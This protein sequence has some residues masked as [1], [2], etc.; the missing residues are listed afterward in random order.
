MC[1][2][3]G[4]I[5]QGITDS[6]TLINT[7][8]TLR[9]RGPDD[10]GI[11]IINGEDQPQLL[12]G[13]DTPIGVRADANKSF[14]RNITD[15]SNYFA[16]L[17]LGHRRL[18][19]QDLTSSGHQ[20]MGFR[21]RYWI[22][23]NGEIYNHQELRKELETQGY[24]FNSTSDTEVI[25]A[26][27]DQWGVQCLQRFNGMW[28]FV[29]YDVSKDEVLISRDRF[30]V[31]PFYFTL[32]NKQMIFASE[33]K[34]LFCHPS[35]S[36][37]P[38]LLKVASYLASGSQEFG[39]HTMFEGILR[40]Q[41]SHYILGKLEDIAA[42]RFKA[43][44]Y[45]KISPTPSYEPFS[46]HQAD[47]LKEQYY[48]LLQDAVRIRLRA[49]VTVGSALS[50][51]LDSSSIVYLINTI[52]SEQGIKDRQLTF[53]T[54]YR[55][56]EV[57]YCDESLY[58]DQM[59]THLGVESNKTEPRPENVPE[60]HAKMIWH[61][62][63]PPDN[64]LMSSWH[65]FKLVQSHG[66]RV[67]LDGQGADE[68]LAGYTGY[69]TSHLISLSLGEWP[70]AIGSYFG[71]YPKKAILTQL[72]YAALIRLFGRGF[73]SKCV[74]FSTPS[75]HQKLL[76]G[77]MP[78]QERLLYDCEHNLQNLLHYA[79]RT[80][81]AFSVESRMP[82]LDYRLA[83]FLSGVGSRY[84]IHAG[85]SKYIA[86]R[87]FDKKL[88]DSI[89]WREDKMG[90][91]IPEKTWF[92]GPLKKWFDIYSSPHT[93]RIASAL[94]ARDRGADLGYRIRVLNLNTWEKCFS[95]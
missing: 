32:K 6:R 45:W 63:T 46:I 86:R 79:D 56:K 65:T 88:P 47:L 40:L 52:L 61:M 90:W 74:E 16:R 11:L 20:P 82:F 27:Y 21:E 36:K 54:V 76:L 24:G 37:Q 95:L 41:N 84:K 31:K 26:A 67:T 58:I 4:I 43:N 62:D 71:K 17:V 87:A 50:G 39:E 72:P 19:I 38:D 48:A 80:S 77:S 66:I 53:S 8:R 75:M 55:Q 49:D 83:E 5:G 89:T 1:G 15:A 91:P 60:Q 94:S 22:V 69:L 44:R 7:S 12:W 2:I 51:G 92:E 68:Q 70:F 59:A 42:G 33:I 29:L 35:I 81:M 30:G 10:E 28:A 34:A 64:T 78:F 85:W 14:H 23:F 13:E 57:A 18:S 9:H 3:F 93:G 73:V 25:M